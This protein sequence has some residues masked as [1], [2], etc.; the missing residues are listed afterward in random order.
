MGVISLTS[1]EGEQHSRP[2][3][4]PEDGK[5]HFR[6]G[7]FDGEFDVGN[8]KWFIEPA[9]RR[10]KT[11]LIAIIP[12]KEKAIQ[13]QLLS[14][15]NETGQVILSFSA[16]DIFRNGVPTGVHT[17][18]EDK[19]LP[20]HSYFRTTGLYY[21][22][23]FSGTIGYQDDWIIITGR[24]KP[25]YEDNPGFGFD[26]AIRLNSNGL[27]WS[28][29]RFSSLKEALNAPTQKVCFLQITNPTFETLPT[30]IYKFEYLE[31]LTIENKPEEG[32]WT[33]SARL[34]FNKISDEIEKLSHLKYLSINNASIEQLPPALGK[35]YKL[36]I[37]NLS[38]CRLLSVPADVWHLPALQHLLMAK[39][40][41][42]EI[43]DNVHLPALVSL[44]IS[45][46]LLTRLPEAILLSQ[47]LKS[48]RASLNPF[49]KLPEK[50]NYFSGL[51]L[52]IDEKRRLLDTSYQGAGGTG[53]IKWNDR[54][55]LADGL[56]D[57]TGPLDKLI[58]D[59]GLDS[60]E[61]P[62]KS[63]VK[64]SIGFQT[65]ED[66]SYQYIGNHRFG[67][68][69]DL[70]LGFEYPL[71][72]DDY[73]GSS[74]KYEFI[75]QINCE[76]IASLQHYLPRVGTLFF[77]LKS[78]HDLSGKVLYEPNNDK[79]HSGA[80]QPESDETFFDLPDEGYRPYQAKAF[81]SC[82]IPSFY[83]LKQNN[84]LLEGA[85]EQLRNRDDVIRSFLEKFEQPVSNI[86]HYVHGI[87]TYAFTQ[88]ESP[89]LQ[90]A[91]L[92]KGNPQDWVILLKL[93]SHGDFQWGDAGELFFVIHKSD[94]AKVDF[95]NVFV[96]LESS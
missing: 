9:V 54:T 49:K 63:L 23:K 17:Y 84:Y 71:F 62:L 22:L 94:L 73:S 92:L 47:G 14:E 35:L 57:L 34:P 87:N 59:N 2:W 78:I 65:I 10:L 4:I 75:A 30:E 25:S 39:N 66:D 36:E 81:Q 3:H 27:D 48:I 18:V 12:D 80:E 91:L 24:L 69:P 70:P 15:H 55:F 19:H 93:S 50:Y 88:H 90:A 44:D 67:G 7:R 31:W 16:F 83:A 89:E 64:L 8:T 79:L 53:T 82:S 74:Y 45:E 76:L 58:I 11:E 86:Y 96:T 29:Y 5:A 61:R 43:P 51:E 26:A 6:L 56:N 40:R 85:A 46:N 72:Y 37:I 21:S 33:D 77:F 20:S 60:L 68:K 52:T 41:I 42:Q 28:K 32:Q 1:N 95:S 38:L 13:E